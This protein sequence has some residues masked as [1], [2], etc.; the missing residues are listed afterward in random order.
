LL[1]DSSATQA[2]ALLAAAAI[3]TVVA[4]HTRNL[5]IACAL[6]LCTVLALHYLTA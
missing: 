3:I 4:Y 2:T 5:T 1:G 6:G